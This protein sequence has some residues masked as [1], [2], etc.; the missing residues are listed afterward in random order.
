MCRPGYEDN[1]RSRVLV[2]VGATLLFT[3]RL[4]VRLSSKLLFLSC[5][6]RSNGVEKA[7]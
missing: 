7:K 2:H 6:F 1:Y 3:V 4:K 5:H